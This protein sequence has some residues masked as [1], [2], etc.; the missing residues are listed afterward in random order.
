MHVLFE[1]I[2]GKSVHESASDR[3]LLLAIIKDIYA[4][5]LNLSAVTDALAK[6]STDVDALITEARAATAQQVIH[7]GQVDALVPSVAALSDKIEAALPK[8]AA[9]A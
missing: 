4:M 3:Q 5:T 7:Q 1:I 6:V 9:A 8:P 2:D